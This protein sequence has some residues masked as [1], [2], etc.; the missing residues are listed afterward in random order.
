[1]NPEIDF[2]YK[3]RLKKEIMTEKD[4]DRYGT[5]GIDAEEFAEVS[6]PCFKMH[7][8]CLW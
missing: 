4:T 2:F 5:S 3:G 7:V 6:E 1:M 8:W